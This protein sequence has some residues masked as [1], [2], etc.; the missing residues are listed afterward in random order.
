MEKR[1]SRHPPD[2][3]TWRT[4]LDDFSEDLIGLRKS[5]NSCCFF[6]ISL[7]FVFDLSLPLIV[8][9]PELQLREVKVHILIFCW[10]ITRPKN[11]GNK[12][13]SH[14]GG[15]QE[16]FPGIPA[17]CFALALFGL[18]IAQKVLVYIHCS[19]SSFF[20]HHT[21]ARKQ[22]ERFRKYRRREKRR[23]CASISSLRY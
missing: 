18:L 1:R 13:I 3:P 14:L 12:D 17:D 2:V 19:I 4:M 11:G 7:C 20:L 9:I 15:R 16:N 22:I 8:L 6:L 21:K 10:C 23:I 5:E